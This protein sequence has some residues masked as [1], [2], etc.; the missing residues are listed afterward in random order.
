MIY[1]I[2]PIVFIA[3]FVLYA[4][5]LILIKKDGAKFKSILVPGLVFIALWGLIYYLWLR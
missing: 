5:Y 4:L 3:V 2:I 1:S